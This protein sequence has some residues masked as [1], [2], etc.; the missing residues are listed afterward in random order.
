MRSEVA[1]G[2]MSEIPKSDEILPVDC[3]GRVRIPRERRE[4]LLEQFDSSGM[5]ATQ[6]AKWAGVKY[7]TFASWLQKRRRECGGPKSKPSSVS[8]PVQWVEAMVACSS[9]TQPSLSAV[10]AGLRITLPEGMTIHVESEAG[11]TLAASLL[12]QLRSLKGC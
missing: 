3:I 6:F 11:V 1:F 7:T 10:E 8:Q 4:A 9:R 2:S 12:K 5:N